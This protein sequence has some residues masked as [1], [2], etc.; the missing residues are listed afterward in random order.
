MI[1]YKI[2]F[3][4]DWKHFWSSVEREI[5]VCHPGAS[6]SY[7]IHFRIRYDA[8][9]K[10]I[11]YRQI[12]SNFPIFNFSTFINSLLGPG[13][14]NLWYHSSVHLRAMLRLAICSHRCQQKSWLIVSRNDRYEVFNYSL[15]DHHES[16]ILWFLSIKYFRY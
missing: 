16:V 15:S 7:S 4:T 2:D 9:I 3:E 1:L 5:T 12:K 8:I 11:D 13:S 14:E 6:I 10:K